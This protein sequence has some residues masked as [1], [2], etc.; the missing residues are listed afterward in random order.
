MLEVLITILWHFAY[1]A[2]CND[3]IFQYFHYHIRL[4]MVELVGIESI[5]IKSLNQFPNFWSPESHEVLANFLGFGE[6]VSFWGCSEIL[7]IFHTPCYTPIAKIPSWEKNFGKYLHYPT[8]LDPLPHSPRDTRRQFFLG[9][10]VNFQVFR[11]YFEDFFRNFRLQSW[12]A[13]GFNLIELN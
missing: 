5:S 13:T 11:G 9:F 10:S 2:F 12:L 7:R 6:F 3:K 1:F 4:S 8:E